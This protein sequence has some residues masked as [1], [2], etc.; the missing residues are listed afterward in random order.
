[1]KYF[2]VT[3]KVNRVRINGVYYNEEHFYTQRVREDKLE[4]FKK[5]HNVI[6]IKE[7]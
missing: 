5:K 1:M 2:K 3:Y 6:N 4:N 7:D